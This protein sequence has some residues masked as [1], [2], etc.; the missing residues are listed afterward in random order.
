M[1]SYPCK[2]IATKIQFGRILEPFKS[3][4]QGHSGRD[5]DETV[6]GAMSLPCDG[7]PTPYLLLKY[8]PLGNG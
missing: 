3:T 6:K 8:D 5:S 2:Y 1:R 7:D 4:L